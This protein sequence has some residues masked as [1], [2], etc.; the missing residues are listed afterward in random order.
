MSMLLGCNK[1]TNA[2]EFI[3]VGVPKVTAG[4]GG[5]GGGEIIEIPLPIS[6]PGPI[7]IAISCLSY[8]LFSQDYIQQ[9]RLRRAF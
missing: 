6:I 8:T 1:D 4:E 5:A 3:I 9:K 7:V 2:P